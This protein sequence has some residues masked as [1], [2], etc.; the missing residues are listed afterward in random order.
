MLTRWLLLA[1]AT[2]AP[3]LLAG[4]AGARR[5]APPGGLYAPAASRG[6]AGAATA[7]E[8]T[9][10][11]LWPA[12][13]FNSAAGGAWR[14]V[15][16]S[17]GQAAVGADCPFT[18][19]GPGG[20]LGACEAACVSAGAAVC[21]DINVNMVIGDC[22][23]R[24]CADPLHPALSPA[25]N[26]SVYALTR[27]PG[28]RL[29]LDAGAFAFRA[30][31]ATN[32][33]LAA[34]LVRARV[35]AFP[36]GRG[37]PSSA[38]AALAALDV[39]VASAD[40]TLVAGVD[41]SY[42]ITI[43]E[44]GATLA[45]VT[46]FGA[47]RG[48][49]TFA[50]LVVYN[51]T[52][53]SY[54]VATGEIRDA[55]RFAYRGV[56]LDTSRHYITISVL[57]E[58]VDVMAAVKLNTLS[59]HLTDDQSWP[60]AVASAPLL[61]EYGAFSNFT[62]VYTPAMIAELVAY[63][64]LRGVR[65]LAEFDTPSHFGALF[66]A[67]PQYAAVT[68]D[69]SLCMVDPSREETFDFLRGIW[70]DLAGSFPA[71]ELRIG[72]DEFQGCWA[73]SPNVT[74]WIAQTFGPKGTIE[75]AY[76]Y[77]VRRVIGIVRGTGRRTQAWLDVHGW[78]NISNETWARDYSDVTLNVWTGCYS[79]SWQAD[80]ARFTAEG[81]DVVVS[82][83]FYVTSNQPGAP[84]FTWQQ[85]YA[86]DLGNFTGGN[87][88]ALAARVRGGELA[89][90]DDAAG[91]DSGDLVVAL[92]PYIFGVAETLWS[93]RAAT[94]GVE[95][96]EQRAHAQRCRLVARGHASHPI[97]AFGTFC[98]KEYESPVAATGG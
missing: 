43:G 72:G 32:D 11:A 40:A 42:N 36:Y 67:Y 24:R 14:K 75:D 29:G 33:V 59:L 13:A 38:P 90:W 37:T 73:D 86:T 7:A 76:H 19:H 79:G 65:L 69:G 41:E 93:P 55:P 63:A 39:V 57:K 20:S 28:A 53:D 50:Q 21:T 92:T 97:F 87:S 94:S 78:P 8:A 51:V 12:P 48:L 74:A 77:F 31:G 56:L 26:Y 30:A 10:A 27:P 6:A 17:D 34:A 35:A 3:S 64:R 81:G 2:A 1:T 9:S 5:A 84:H 83:P 89:V 22:V 45:A 58:V 25:A 46:A 23:F 66:A 4:R 15:A 95:P 98:A 82:G 52:E 49:E 68:K 18:Q 71:D 88:T 70:R 80:V 62:H 47:L 44:S 61:A 16:G 60:V 54:E 85:M 96:D 91:T